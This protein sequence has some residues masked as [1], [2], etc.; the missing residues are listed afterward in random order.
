[1]PGSLNLGAGGDPEW[2]ASPP[3]YSCL[4]CLCVGILVCMNASVHTH[5]H[6]HTHTGRSSATPWEWSSACA[7][8]TESRCKRGWCVPRKCPSLWQSRTHTGASECASSFRADLVLYDLRIDLLDA[9]ADAP[10]ALQPDLFRSGLDVPGP[11]EKDEALSGTPQ[12]VPRGLVCAAVQRSPQAVFSG[13]SSPV[14]RACT[15]GMHTLSM[16]IVVSQRRQNCEKL[17]S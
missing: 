13:A 12:R 8:P 17:S 14:T 6:T 10:V 3:T 16:T 15:A 1:M 9:L 7:P 5:T 4:S 2:C 11:L